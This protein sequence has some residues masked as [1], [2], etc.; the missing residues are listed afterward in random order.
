M[1]PSDVR[2]ISSQLEREPTDV[3]RGA[4]L[5]RE[6]LAGTAPKF[7]AKRNAAASCALRRMELGFVG[8]VNKEC[9][10]I[11]RRRRRSPSVGTF[12][13][14][15]VEDIVGAST[16]ATRLSHHRLQLPSHC[17]PFGIST[18][19][20]VTIKKGSPLSQPIALLQDL[21]N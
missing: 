4:R 1:G 21:R 16:G 20:L 17:L 8:F 9:M 14:A 5:G 7:Q 2:S 11:E 15:A 3:R 12:R 18:P 6:P 10:Q 13:N 19:C